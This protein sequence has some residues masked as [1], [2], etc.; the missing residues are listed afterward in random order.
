MTPARLERSQP[1]V[2]AYSRMPEEVGMLR[3]W[4]RRCAKPKKQPAAL[5]AWNAEW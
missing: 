1:Y 2:P 4:S 5:S 3:S